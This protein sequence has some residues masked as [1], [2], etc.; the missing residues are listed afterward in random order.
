MALAGKAFD[1]K[2]SRIGNSLDSNDL[3]MRV[4]VDLENTNNELR[5]GMF[6]HVTV[7]LTRATKEL[8]VP[9]TALVGSA[10][11]TTTSVYAVENGLAKLLPVKVGRDNGVQA[12]ILSG[13]KA[14]DLI[15]RHPT[16]DLF[17][18]EKVTPVKTPQKAA[19]AE[20]NAK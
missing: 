11:G 4:E 1:A 14:G 8:S 5:D 3:T 17:S 7:D 10:E 6:V 12:E 16:S 20:K 18:G 2:V 19:I 15:V 9:S 13:I